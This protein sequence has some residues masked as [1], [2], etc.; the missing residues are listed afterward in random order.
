MDVHNVFRINFA[1]QNRLPLHLY[2][3]FRIIVDTLGRVLRDYRRCRL[4]ESSKAGEEAIYTMMF[5][6]LM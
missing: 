6:V 4:E 2:L 3:G 1:P 5:H